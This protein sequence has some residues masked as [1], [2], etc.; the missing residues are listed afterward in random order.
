MAQFVTDDACIRPSSALPT[1][2]EEENDQ[3]AEEAGDQV[4]EEAGDEDWC[5]SRVYVGFM[6]PSPLRE[7]LELLSSVAVILFCVVCWDRLE[8]LPVN[9]ED[10]GPEP[11][12]DQEDGEEQDKDGE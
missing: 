4:A 7:N 1:M 8:C 9:Y 11:E 6:L 5:M 10:Q 2:A 3:V 12:L